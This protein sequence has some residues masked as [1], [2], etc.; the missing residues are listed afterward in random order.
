MRSILTVVTILV[1]STPTAGGGQSWQSHYERGDY[2]VAAALL[3]PLVFN[4]PAK[5]SDPPMPDPVAAE[6]LARMYWDGRGVP[7]DRIVGCALID[8]ALALTM[9]RF[10][11]ADHP[12][13]A[14]MQRLQTST[15]DTLPPEE[16]LEAVDM[17]LCPKF[18]PDR[19]VFD[20]DGGP[21]LEISRRGFRWD[22][23]SPKQALPLAMPCLE[24]VVLVRHSRVEPGSA[25][26]ASPR[27]LI[28]LYSWRPADG[29]W[30]DRALM[31]TLMELV[32]R[33]IEMRD[34]RE[35]AREPGPT[36]PK[37]EAP[38]RHTDVRFAMSAD[39]DMSW[40]FNGT[41]VEGTLAA[42]PER[43]PDEPDVLPA[44]GTKG[45]G[46]V[47]VNIADRS[48]R[49]LENVRDPADGRRRIG[50]PPRMPM[51]GSRS[52]VSPPAGT[53]WWHPRRAW[54]RPRLGFST[55]PNPA[56]SPRT[57]CSSPMVP[58]RQC[59]SDAVVTIQAR[60]E[61]W[62]LAPTSCST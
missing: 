1:L 28:E 24:R 51:D 33:K 46:H 32:G 26:D 16:R 54:R 10:P 59:R 23:Q 12:A 37:L 47:S 48:G 25:S 44:L 2:E 27:H 20:L 60:S 21:S 61:R 18:G 17:T 19:Q 29:A 38:P 50:R 49:P 9:F 53:T 22:D 43:R 35:L 56:A 15:C 11:S 5:P 6:T 31:W 34:Q 52:E 55:S 3:H 36:W 39:G 62:P 7:Q 57:W 40:R 14:A 30:A 8:V 42:L 41:P 58:A 4:P 13:V 45:T